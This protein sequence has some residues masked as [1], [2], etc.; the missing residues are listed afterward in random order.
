M[1]E[2][3]LIYKDDSKEWYFEHPKRGPQGPFRTEKE[4]Q[5]NLY[6]RAEEEFKTHFTVES[7]NTHISK[8]AYKVKRVYWMEQIRNPQSN[9]VAEIQ[10]TALKG[11][12]KKTVCC[13]T[14]E[15]IY[16]T[17][18]KATRKIAK[19]EGE[20]FVLNGAKT[21]EKDERTAHPGVHGDQ[22]LD[23]FKKL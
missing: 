16:E 23:L 10:H 22:L 9:W 6:L 14:G 5:I 13:S 2:E 11:S 7:F 18:L 3:V 8:W 15:T 17:L 21:V 12:R 4:T 19:F 1:T 20:G